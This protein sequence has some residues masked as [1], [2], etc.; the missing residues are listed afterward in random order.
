MPSLHYSN[1]LFADQ[2][3]NDLIDLKVCC[4]EVVMKISV[5]SELRSF[6]FK[7]GIF[8]YNLVTC[9]WPLKVHFSLSL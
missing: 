2:N 7:K 9:Y 5:F 1:I 3:T 4:D 8:N 6:H